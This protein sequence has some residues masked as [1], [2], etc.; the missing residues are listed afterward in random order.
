MPRP[1]HDTATRAANAR[2]PRATVRQTSSCVRVRICL[3]FDPALAIVSC[4]AR[5][6]ARRP[7]PRLF[8][9]KLGSADLLRVTLATLSRNVARSA[10]VRPHE[11]VNGPQR[12]RAS[13]ESPELKSNT[14]GAS[15]GFAHTRRARSRERTPMMRKSL[16]VPSEVC[17]DRTLNLVNLRRSSA[18]REARFGFGLFAGPSRDER[19]SGFRTRARVLRLASAVMSRTQLRHS[20]VDHSPMVISWRSRETDQSLKPTRD[21]VGRFAVFARARRKK[22]SLTRVSFHS[23]GFPFA[24]AR[25][26]TAGL[27][28]RATMRDCAVRRSIGSEWTEK[29]NNRTPFRDPRSARMTM[30]A[31]TDDRRRTRST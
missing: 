14:S 23:L 25:V 15:L 22:V 10:R 29:R 11:P 13:P 8:F 20:S 30:T 9:G 1:E 3:S 17:D 5:E 31:K 21:G 27:G 4:R 24:R 18:K 26:L 12:A 19:E 6:R 28:R 16:S 2:P 7:L